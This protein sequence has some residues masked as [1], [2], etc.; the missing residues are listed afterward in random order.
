MGIVLL[1]VFFNIKHTTM[2]AQ[3]R[4]MAILEALNIGPIELANVTGLHR[5]RIFDLSRGKVKK[6]SIEVADAISG[7]F[8]AVNKDWLLYEQGD[9]MLKEAQ[10]E[11]DDD[12]SIKKYK[13]IINE[14]LSVIAT[15]NAQLERASQDLNRA[16][17]T[18]NQLA[19]NKKSPAITSYMVAEDELNNNNEI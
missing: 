7:R 17:D 8:P 2:T 11:Q 1:L 13:T 4:I 14:L 10:S 9:M 12:E 18:I 19:Q 5:N 3:E 16:L 6:I 15:Q